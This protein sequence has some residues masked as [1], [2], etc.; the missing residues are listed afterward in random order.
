MVSVF[1]KMRQ[2][3]AMHT[4]M[5]LTSEQKISL[6]RKVHYIEGRVYQ[7][8]FLPIALRNAQAYW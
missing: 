2:Y 6:E 5:E 3:L 4:K 7:N 8:L 1:G